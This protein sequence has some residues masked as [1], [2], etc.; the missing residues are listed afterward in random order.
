M[1]RTTR[2]VGRAFLL[3]LA[4]ISGLWLVASAWGGHVNPH[5]WAL[6]SVLGL[7][8]PVALVVVISL[9]VIS[10]LMRCWKTAVGLLLAVLVS[11]PTLR[12]TVPMNVSHAAGDT[13]RTFSLVT[14][15]VSGFSNVQGVADEMATIHYILDSNADFVLL[16][17]ATLECPD[18]FKSRHVAPVK[19]EVDRKYPYHAHGYHDLMIL[20]RYPYAVHTDTTLRTTYQDDSYHYYAKAYDLQLPEGRQLRIINVHLQSIGLTDGDRMVYRNL[21]RLD[22][23]NSRKQMRQVRSSLYAKLAGAY[24]RRSHE[25]ALVRKMIDSSDSNVIL[26][27][28]FNDTPA[29]YSYLTMC[30]DDMKDVFAQRGRGYKHTF[31]RDKM[32]F[33]ID[34]VLYRGNLNAVSIRRDKKGASDHYPLLATFEWQD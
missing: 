9:L 10:L 4:L 28:D 23:I 30:G 27:G 25:A 20:S 34:H 15:N 5:T 19:D 8:F 14:F 6:P 29:S 24:R 3:I 12:V 18:L 1:L 16:Q 17:E 32:L 31:N 33:E 7:T 2:I 21:T 26:C 13:T 11:W 22:S